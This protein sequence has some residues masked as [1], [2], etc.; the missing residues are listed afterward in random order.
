M[1][2]RARTSA[3]ALEN[4]VEG[5]GINLMQFCSYCFGEQ[6]PTRDISHQNFVLEKAIWGWSA[7]SWQVSDD[8]NQGGELHPSLLLFSSMVVPSETSALL[9]V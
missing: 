3:L 5:R 1:F 7:Q 4:Y 6:T 9:H 8:G 2:L